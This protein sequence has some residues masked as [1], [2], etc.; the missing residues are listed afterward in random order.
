[1]HFCGKFK[2]KSQQRRLTRTKERKTEPQIVSSTEQL[3]RKALFWQ[4]YKSLLLCVAASLLGL[5]GINLSSSDQEENGYFS[6][7]KKFRIILSSL[8]QELCTAAVTKPDSFYA[9]DV[10]PNT[11]LSQNQTNF[12]YF[13]IKLKAFLQV[14]TLAIK[15]WEFEKLMVI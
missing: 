6:S 8:L 5:S 13:V 9:R 1:M 11:Y 7:G 12:E 2:L 4:M 14:I 3:F 15:I 10:K